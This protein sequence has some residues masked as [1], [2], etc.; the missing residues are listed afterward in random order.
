M[1]AADYRNTAFEVQPSRTAAPV[2]AGAGAA[3]P[4]M[5]AKEASEDPL[6]WAIRLLPASRRRAMEALYRF[7]RE[8]DGIAADRSSPLLKQAFLSDWRAEIALLY[9]GR[10]RR[11]VT[12]GL[13]EPVQRYGLRCD[14][15]LTI[16]NGLEMEI[17]D[18]AEMASP[19]D[20]DLHSAR[21]A[22]AMS[23][24]ATRILGLEERAATQFATALGQGLH[25][26]RILRDLALDASRNRLHLPA[27]L[28]A[29]HCV[30]ATDPRAV[31]AH[32]LI[33]YACRE[34]A[35]TAE[36]HYAAA[37]EA[38]AGRHSQEMRI[39]ALMLGSCRGL[40]AAV[41]ARGWGRL[42]KPVRLSAR[43]KAMLLL[44][45]GLAGM[46]ALL[47]PRVDGL[48]GPARRARPFAH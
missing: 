19:G 2:S 36:R 7:W 14:D 22:I 20:F 48:F 6:F 34:L 8:I 43:R 1:T 35:A 47:R 5:C 18:A 29:A 32:P 44:R 40:H 4:L 9:D 23:R 33:D 30:E 26:T 45:Y 38:I 12:V 10:P 28:L 15:F 25:L 3:L 17:R 11:E 42:E 24:L 41:L 27:E 46:G 16:V 21:A 13:L 39:A 31:L 37:G